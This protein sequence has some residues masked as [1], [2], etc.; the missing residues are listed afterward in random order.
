MDKIAQSVY[1]YWFGTEGLSL[2]AVKKRAS[3]WWQGSAD[4][5]YD[6][7]RRFGKLVEAAG[8]RSFDNWTHNARS[9]LALIILNDQFPRNLY[10]GSGKAFSHD[11]LALEYSRQLVNSDAFNE[12]EPIEKTFSL[13]PFEHSENIEDQEFSVAKFTELAESA[14]DEWQEQMRFYLKYAEDHRDIIKDF[15]RFPH[16]NQVLA[17]ESTPQEIDYLESGGHRFG[18]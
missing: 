18:Q 5:D 7:E 15:G 2:E 9:A 11:P 16:R 14:D 6:I 4:T 8:K 10:R 13:M 17:R 1:D 12:L 3:L